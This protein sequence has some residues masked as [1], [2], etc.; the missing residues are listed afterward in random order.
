MKR[1]HAP[2]QLRHE[3]GCYSAKRHY[4]RVRGQRRRCFCRYHAQKLENNELFDSRTVSAGLMAR[5]RS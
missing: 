1:G 3:A 5:S 2:N 4:S